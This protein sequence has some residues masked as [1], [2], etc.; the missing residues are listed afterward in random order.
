M[1][2]AIYNPATN[3]MHF[4]Y[5]FEDNQR[6]DDDPIPFGK[7]LTSKIME[8]GRPLLVKSNWEEEVSKYNPIYRNKK[9]G[10]SSI[11]IPMMIR[12]GAIVG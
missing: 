3:L 6:Q 12:D 11:S 2:I 7:G 8:M 10:K 1:Y 9:R 5:D 4:P